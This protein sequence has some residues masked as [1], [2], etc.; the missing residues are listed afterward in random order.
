MTLGTRGPWRKL[1]QIGEGYFGK[2]Y[3]WCSD[4]MGS[5]AAKRSS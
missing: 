4:L 1:K 5:A 2:V 3:T